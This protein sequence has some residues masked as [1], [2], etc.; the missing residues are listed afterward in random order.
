MDPNTYKEAKLDGAIVEEH[1][2]G[3]IITVKVTEYTRKGDPV[4]V[5]HKQ[6][7]IELLDTRAKTQANLDVIDEQIAAYQALPDEKV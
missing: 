2:E 1:K 6:S 4:E 7:L 5:E 3:D